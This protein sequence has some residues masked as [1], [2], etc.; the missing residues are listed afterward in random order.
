MVT[1]FHKS[2]RVKGADGVRG[3]LRGCYRII[4]LVA[5]RAGV[6]RQRIARVGGGDECGI[7]ARL[8][9]MLWNRCA[10]FHC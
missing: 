1:P 4:V 3:P 2:R 10:A 9:V 6:N 7:P 5:I 8:F